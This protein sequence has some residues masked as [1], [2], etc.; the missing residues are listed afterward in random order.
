MIDNAFNMQGNLSPM[1]IVA[2]ATAQIAKLPASSPKAIAVSAKSV[3]LASNSNET[4]T[5]S[6]P[7]VSSKDKLDALAL[8]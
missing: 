5:I 7:D 8:N 3:T 1:A 4:E 6:L 2:S